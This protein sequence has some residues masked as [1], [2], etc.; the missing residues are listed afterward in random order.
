MAQIRVALDIEVEKGDTDAIMKAV[1]EER[2]AIAN[3]IKDVIIPASEP[4]DGAKVA[5]LAGGSHV[6]D[7]SGGFCTM[8]DKYSRKQT[9]IPIED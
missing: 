1:F 9:L 2:G 8:C 3:F 7:V 5:A 4:G 6:H